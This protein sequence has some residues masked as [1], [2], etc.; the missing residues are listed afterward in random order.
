MDAHEPL[1]ARVAVVA[2]VSAPA[3][4]PAV[5]AGSD[6]AAWALAVAPVVGAAV[7]GAAVVGAAVVGAAA[8]GADS[9]AAV[10]VMAS[11]GQISM[12]ARQLVHSE[13]TTIGRFG[14][15][16]R[17]RSGQVTRQRPH[18]VHRPSIMTVPLPARAKRANGTSRANRVFN[19]IPSA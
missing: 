17:A 7:V 13:S 19:D 10:S 1:D 16:R 9:T 6:A 3:V 18:A 11:T 12:Q 15:G 2:M 14:A 8:S 4:D 5:G